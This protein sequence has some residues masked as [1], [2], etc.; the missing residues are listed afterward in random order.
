MWTNLSVQVK[1]WDPCVQY[2]ENTNI[3]C[4]EK[5]V[6]FWEWFLHSWAEIRLEMYRWVT[7]YALSWGSRTVLCSMCRDMRLE[8]HRWVTNYA[9]TWGSQTVPCFVCPDMRL[10]VYTW[11][12]NHALACVSRTVPCSC[13]F[14]TPIPAPTHRNFMNCMPIWDTNFALTWVL[15]TVPCSM[16]SEPI[17]APTQ[18]KPT[19]SS[20]A[21]L[22]TCKDAICLWVLQHTA[23]HCHTLQHTTTY[24]NIL[25][26]I[27]QCA[28]TYNVCECCNIL[29]HEGTHCCTL[30]NTAT[31]CNTLELIILQHIALR[32]STH[33]VCECCSTL[34]PAATHSITLQHTTKHCNTLQHIT[35]RTRTHKFAIFC[36]CVSKPKKS[37]IFHVVYT[38]FAHT[39]DVIWTMSHGVYIMCTLICP[40]HIRCF[41]TICSQ[42]VFRVCTIQKK[43]CNFFWGF[44]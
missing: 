42:F 43:S 37:I 12:T 17:P 15:R 40:K 19:N 28:K 8:V 34:Q 32:E 18:R 39:H 11:V 26:H 36:V 31:H 35:L 41:W 2:C 38:I 9:L 3:T 10:E 16:S 22:I 7:N 24:W 14:E 20:V 1:S 30:Q 23:T 29:Q 44:V 25:Q 27:T 5:F 4:V 33:D 21:S 6:A 13:V